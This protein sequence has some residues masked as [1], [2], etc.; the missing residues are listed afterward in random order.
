M[1][2]LYKSFE[3]MYSRG[4]DE[5]EIL[6]TLRQE[7]P[8]I[9]NDNTINLVNSECE[10]GE[11]KISM[12]GL[13]PG[14][15]VNI[16]YGKCFGIQDILNI[17]NHPDSFLN[18]KGKIINPF[19]KEVFTPEIL[20]KFDDLLESVGLGEEPYFSLD[21]KIKKLKLVLGGRQWDLRKT[22]R[23]LKRYVRDLQEDPDEIPMT[24]SNQLLTDYIEDEII[25]QLENNDDFLESWLQINSLEDYHI[26]ASLLKEEYDIYKGLGR[27]QRSIIF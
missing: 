11:S 15:Y 18:D 27:A 25:S 8:D 13:T 21:T 7:F 17:K 22:I 1:E 5:S 10:D 19:T 4:L 12:T 3:R 26:I 9:V 14:L 6:M 23:A 2:L 16:G 24:G 20:K